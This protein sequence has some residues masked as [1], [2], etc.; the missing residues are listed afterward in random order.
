MKKSKYTKELLEPIVKNSLSWAQAIEKLGLNKTGGNYRNIQSHVRYHELDTSHFRG[1]GWSRGETK[2]SNKTVSKITRKISLSPSSALIE[3]YPGT[4][5][6]TRL[7]TLLLEYGFEYICANG[8]LPIWMNEEL[9]LHVDHINGIPNDNRPENLRFL[10]P[11]CHQ[12]TK[13]WG[14]K[15][16]K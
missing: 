1:Q 9:T 7:K 5:S 14:N 2:H 10:C 12:Q 6:G 16:R 4:I 11:N 3:N 13:T 15:K 8:H